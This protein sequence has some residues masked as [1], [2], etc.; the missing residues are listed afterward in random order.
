MQQWPEPVS[1]AAAILLALFI[2]RFYDAR[3][4]SGIQGRHSLRIRLLFTLLAVFAGGYLFAAVTGVKSNGVNCF[5]TANLLFFACVLG[6]WMT[7]PLKRPAE[8]VPLCLVVALAD[9]FSVA[10]GPTKHLAEDLSAFYEGGMAGMPPLVDFLLVKTVVPGREVLMP[11][12]GISDWIIVVFLSSAAAKFNMDDNIWVRG[13]GRIIR[14]LFF[15]VGCAGLAV[16]IAAAWLAGLFIPALPFVVAAFLAVMMGRY[17][18]MRRLTKAEFLPMAVV[19]GIL[20]VLM[21]VF[22]IR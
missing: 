19:S 10:A 1:A 14:G 12:F 4:E 22:Y 6:N 3:V 15:P 16:S 11:L 18:E 5:L 2:I 13:D 7:W 9:L 20:I 17:P 21:A 8:I